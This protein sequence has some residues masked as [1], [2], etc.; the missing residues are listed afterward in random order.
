MPRQPRQ[1]NN[2]ARA[3]PLRSLVRRG[4][5][6]GFLLLCFLTSAP[7]ALATSGTIDPVYKYAFSNVGGWMNFNPSNAGL[8]ITDSLVTG[9]A[10]SANDGWINFAP[11]NGGVRNDNQGHLSGY[12]WD[13]TAGWVNFAGVTIDAVGRFHGQAV[14]GTTNGASYIINFDCTNCNVTTDWI[15]ASARAQGSI[16]PIYYPP[17]VQSSATPPPAPEPPAG[18]LPPIKTPTANSTKSATP[19]GAVYPTKNASSTPPLATNTKPM[20]KPI[21]SSTTKPVAQPSFWHSAT[22]PV[23][24]GVSL[25][26]IL[27]LLWWVF[28]L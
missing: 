15:P 9:Y 4:V 8:T 27:G 24:G 21:V 2:I 20:K 17:L 22:L 13:Q 19:G 7:H 16:S 23:V 18:Q 5:V 12:A 25:V 3:A 11:T 6:H 14:G 10:W 26:A 28:F 1:R